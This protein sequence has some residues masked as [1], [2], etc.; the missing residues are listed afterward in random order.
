MAEGFLIFIRL[1]ILIG[2]LYAL[3]KYR[4]LSSQ[5]GYCDTNRPSNAI[6][7]E[8]VAEYAE[9]TQSTDEADSIYSLLLI[10]LQCT[11]CP[12]YAYCSQGQIDAC[13]AEFLLTESLISHI[14]FSSLL[15]GMPYLGPVAFPQRCE[16]DSD[17]RAMAADVAVHVL[18]TL[19]KHRGDVVCGGIRRRRGLS[20]LDAFALGEDD[21]YAFISA[22]KDVRGV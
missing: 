6:L 13:E 20:D 21:V 18:S 11:P 4:S 9:L 7:D 16:P 22:L 14:P 3:L 12:Q 17:K 10:P 1:T 8:R 2:A 15:N 5:L 19:E